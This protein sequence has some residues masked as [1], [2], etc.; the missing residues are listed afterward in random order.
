M[1]NHV[2]PYWII[3]RK[4]F[5][6]YEGDQY[7][8]FESS[9][10]AWI[11]LKKWVRNKG[12]FSST[13]LNKGTSLFHTCTVCLKMFIHPLFLRPESDEFC[14]ASLQ[15]QS[16]RFVKEA[17]TVVPPRIHSRPPADTS[18]EEKRG[19]ACYSIFMFGYEGEDSF[20]KQQTQTQS[21]FFL[22]IGL[23]LMLAELQ[24]HGKNK[25]QT[26]GLCFHSVEN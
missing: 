26:T 1:F 13:E 5:I 6:D 2:Q 23:S 7:C 11:A 8:A 18:S 21:S 3:P 17:G 10:V 25:R 22:D 24:C 15:R 20:F 16:A 4:P 12:N 19:D 9:T 14:I